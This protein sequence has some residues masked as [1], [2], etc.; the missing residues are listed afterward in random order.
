MKAS[1]PHPTAAYHFVPYL[2]IIIVLLVYTLG[3]SAHNGLIARSAPSAHQYDPLTFRAFVARRQVWQAAALDPA[4]FPCVRLPDGG[5]LPA[6]ASR[7]DPASDITP[8]GDSVLFNALLCYAGDLRGCEAVAASQGP[9]GRWWRSPL[10]VG[11]EDPRTG[12]DRQTSFSRDHALGVLLYLA[13]TQ[14]AQ[15]AGRWLDWMDDHRGPLGQLR[16][17]P[18]PKSVTDCDV[19]PNLYSLMYKVWSAIP[20]LEPTLEMTLFK[21][22]GDEAI[23]LQAI[24]ATSPGY[25]LHLH[26]VDVLI[27]RVT[28]Q[29]V[30][31]SLAAAIVAK[32][33]DNTFYRWLDGQDPQSIAAD[34][35]D[36]WC[37]F[38]SPDDYRVGEQNDWI[39]QRDTAEPGL[40][41][42][43]L[44]WDCLFVADLLDIPPVDPSLLPANANGALFVD[45]T[46]HAGGNG[47]R[48]APFTTV[49]AAHA[50]AWD[51]AVLA[52]QAGAY[53]ESLVLDRRVALLP[54]GGI[55]SIEGK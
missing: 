11:W 21:N 33:P 12:S 15:A 20:G 27:K 43:T 16:V 23:S 40:A 45:G 46:A 2:L 3:A 31:S 8:A 37:V 9:D 10:H 26:V 4:L 1:R 24:A 47:S 29:G 51:G 36:R 28:G 55:I 39:W 18:D 14:D 34:V 6:T 48:R 42:R 50:A 17:C 5:V 35:L 32:Q 38:D 25:Q 19:T 22:A 52:I 30:T 49:T 54:I 13:L 7:C 53:N 41:E 44:A